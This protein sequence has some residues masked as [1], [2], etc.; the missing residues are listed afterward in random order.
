MPS[1]TLSATQDPSPNEVASETYAD[2][3]MVAHVKNPTIFTAVGDRT[4]S[5]L[6]WWNASVSVKVQNGYPRQLD[7]MHRAE[8]RLRY[9]QCC[10]A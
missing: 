6:S 5:K 10:L 9:L 2:S 7:A 1:T 3:E 8:L 4:D